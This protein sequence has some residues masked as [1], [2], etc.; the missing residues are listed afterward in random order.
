M[1]LTFL[2]LSALVRRDA[3]GGASD[4]TPRGLSEFFRTVDVDGDGQIEPTEAMHFM[5]QHFG[6][7][8]KQDAGKLVEHMSLNLD[9]SDRDVTISQQEVEK[10]LHNLLKVKIGQTPFALLWWRYY[11]A[12]HAYLCLDPR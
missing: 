9:G 2:V 5:D 7:T 12:A 8:E 10:H 3:A 6:P 1:A 4:Q 11:V